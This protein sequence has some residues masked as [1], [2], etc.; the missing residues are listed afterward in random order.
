MS[1]SRAFILID[2]IF[3]LEFALLTFRHLS[4]DEEIG[5]LTLSGTQP[6]P[7]VMSSTCSGNCLVAND[8]T[9]IMSLSTSC[10]LAAYS[11]RD[12]PMSDSVASFK[13]HLCCL[14]LALNGLAGMS[15]LI[16]ANIF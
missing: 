8:Y 15:A 5:I 10:L 3:A 13:V 7:P 16:F 2:P 14:Q 1:V 12:I 9:I 4:N 11:K 6:L